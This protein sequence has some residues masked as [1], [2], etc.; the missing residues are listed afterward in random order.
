LGDN[1]GWVL[2]LND[3]TEQKRLEGLKSEFINI[4]AHELRTPLAGVMGFVSVLK[5]E[6]RDNDNPGAT[7]II[8]LILQST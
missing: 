2:V 4:A 8:D 1:Q 3:L 5:E 7:E 6:F